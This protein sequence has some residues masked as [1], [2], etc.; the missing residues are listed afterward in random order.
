MFLLFLGM[1]DFWLV[2][3]CFPLLVVLWN[4]KR[5]IIFSVLLHLIWKMLL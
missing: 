3:N 5:I 2:N 4:V 1:I